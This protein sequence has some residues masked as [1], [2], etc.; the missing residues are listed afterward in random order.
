MIFFIILIYPHNFFIILMIKFLVL[1]TMLTD[2]EVETD[3]FNA[4]FF[5]P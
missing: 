1:S 4:F 2:D 5:F 3:F